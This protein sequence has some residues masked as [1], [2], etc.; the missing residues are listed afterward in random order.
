[1][2]FAEVF[3]QRGGFDIAIANPPY[4][5][6]IRDRR[7]G[8]ISQTDSYTNFMA[9][10]T[11]VMPSGVMAYITPTSWE[12]GE[13]YKKF[14][15]FLFGNVALRSLVNLPY[16]VFE[17]PY[18][19]TAITVGL[20]NSTPPE[21]FRLATFQKRR[22]LDLTQ[23]A[24]HL[25]PIQWS[26]ITDDAKLRLPLLG[27]GANLFYRISANATTLDKVANLK[28]GIESYRYEILNEKSP[29]AHPFFTGQLHRYEISPSPHEAFVI[30]SGH[31]SPFHEGP[32]ILTRRI[33]SRANRLMS[34]FTDKEFVVK[35]D[36]Y[37]LK[38]KSGHGNRLTIL[39]AILNS[40]LMSFLYLSRSSA[41]TKDDFR[42]VTLT[43]LRELPVVFPGKRDEVELVRLVRMREEHLEQAGA[44][45]H[46]IDQLVYHIYGITDS[47]Q[48][49][50]EE[51][52][53]QPG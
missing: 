40:S 51:W 28:R 17:T 31:D 45:D 37:S 13:G 12:T 48:N 34:A 47:E 18:V 44:L 52:L 16:D 27:W 21:S 53:S 4:G 9:L 7:S 23:I 50:I 24:D 14:R 36:F 2:H 39:L 22:Q 30:V 29:I 33:V 10:A 3:A 49:A 26:V 1:M 5:I 38:L 19:D 46:R 20:V 6:T 8:A 35:K 11:E 43:G 15:Q 32:R 42:Q 25:E 41:A